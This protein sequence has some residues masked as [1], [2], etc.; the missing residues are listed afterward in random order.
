MVC[1]ASALQHGLLHNLH[2]AHAVL[3][4][5]PWSRLRALREEAVRHGMAAVWRELRVDTLCADLL[6]VAADGLP[7]KHQWLLVLPPPR[8]QGP[9]A[10]ARIGLWKPMSACL[11]AE[12]S[13][14]CVWCAQRA[15][16]LP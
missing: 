1:S 7:S 3:A 14:C 10:T 6:E 12:R 15:M 13:A 9:D 8:S 16:V 11:A 2:N 4:R 5:H